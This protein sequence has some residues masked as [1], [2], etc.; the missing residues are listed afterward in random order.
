[1]AV[2]KKILLADRIIPSFGGQGI[3]LQLVFVQLGTQWEKKNCVIPT[4]FFCQD[5]LYV[6]LFIFYIKMKI[7]LFYIIYYEMY[8]WLFEIRFSVIITAAMVVV[9][10]L[11]FCT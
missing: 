7:P 10:Q 1:M 3:Q 2:K 6:F 4:A 5:Y 8:F 9:L 11:D